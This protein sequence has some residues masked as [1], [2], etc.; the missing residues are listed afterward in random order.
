MASGPITSWQIQGEKVE[1]MTDFLFLASKIIADSDCSQ[2]LRHL[3]LGKKAIA[4]LGSILKKQK[5][6]FADKNLYSQS[7]GHVWM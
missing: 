1:T 5:Q 4:N 3:L 6:Q 7:Y 2:K